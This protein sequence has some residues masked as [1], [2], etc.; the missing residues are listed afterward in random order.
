MIPCKIKGDGFSATLPTNLSVVNRVTD[1]YGHLYAISLAGHAQQVQAI[2]SALTDWSMSFSWDMSQEPTFNRIGIERW[3]TPV[4]PAP[5]GFEVRKAKLAFDTWHLVAVSKSPLFFL[6]D[7]DE[8]LWRVIRSDKFTT[9]LLRHW[10]PTIRKTLHEQGALKK[11]DFFGRQF[12]KH[13]PPA[14][15]IATTETLDKV[16]SEGVKFGRLK[17]QKAA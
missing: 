2:C 11:C 8:A 12:D 14:Y 16:V 10:A 17:I 9:P 4:H 3:E 7:T 13:G 15:L 1:K 6:H 5:G